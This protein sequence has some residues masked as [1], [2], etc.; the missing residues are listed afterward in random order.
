[1]PSKE[2]IVKQILDGRSSDPSRAEAEAFAP[3]NI[4]LCKYWGKRDDVLNLPATPSLS[5]S[6]GE[7]GSRT[8]LRR[9]EGAEV[10]KVSFL[11]GWGLCHVSGCISR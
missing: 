8:W 9:G 3:A 1:M 4:A 10:G 11:F 7:R 2:D 5:I 6:L